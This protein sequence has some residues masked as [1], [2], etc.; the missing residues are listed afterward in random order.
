MRDRCD[1]T[2]LCVEVPVAELATSSARHCDR[3]RLVN[4]GAG[5][6][7]T[8]DLRFARGGGP[9]QSQRPGPLVTVTG[10]TRGCSAT[11][12]RI[13]ASTRNAARLQAWN[14]FQSRF[15]FPG[16]AEFV[17][18]HCVESRA[19]S[20]RSCVNAPDIGRILLY[21]SSTRELMLPINRTFN[22]GRSRAPSSDFT[23]SRWFNCCCWALG[24]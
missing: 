8:N 23:H 18:S 11:S 12:H 3:A 6:S 13:S 2:G 22:A 4:S 1:A 10:A 9:D 16:N 21:S 24:L 17:R 15:R 19:S 7:L 14:R 20:T 5:A